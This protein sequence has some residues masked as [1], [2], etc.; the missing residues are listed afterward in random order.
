MVDL[1]RGL[2]H[3]HFS[4]WQPCGRPVSNK[5]GYERIVR[6]VPDFH[7]V[8]L[9]AAGGSLLRGLPAATHLFP[10]HIR[11]FGLVRARHHP[12][13]QR[14]SGNLRLW[15]LHVAGWA[16]GVRGEAAGRVSSK[17]EL[18]F[19]MIESHQLKG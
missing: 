9:W 2:A 3:S 7:P 18:R 4:H 10:N 19:A 8:A 11:F 14:L 15:L 5:L 17:F 1:W 13:S 16:E 6:R 12:R